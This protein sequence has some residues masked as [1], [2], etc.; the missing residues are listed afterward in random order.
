MPEMGAKR[1]DRFWHPACDRDPRQ[2]VDG[3]LRRPQG[4]AD[5]A[6]AKDGLAAQVAQAHAGPLQTFLDRL[7]PAVP[8]AKPCRLTRAVSYPEG[9]RDSHARTHLRA[10][11]IA[12][13]GWDRLCAAV[14]SIDHE[15]VVTIRPRVRAE[16]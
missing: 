5:A 16:A 9:M 2:P 11:D 7:N 13:W 3:Q 6:R 8:S 14:A 4:Q 1:N 10:G 12:G 15:I